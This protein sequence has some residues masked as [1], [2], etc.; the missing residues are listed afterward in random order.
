VIFPLVILTCMGVMRQQYLEGIQ[1]KQSSLQSLKSLFTSFTGLLSIVTYYSLAVFY[2][3]KR[4]VGF[5]MRYMI[6]NI[7]Y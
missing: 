6:A 1:Q 3:Y 2:M 4:N 5:H 7:G